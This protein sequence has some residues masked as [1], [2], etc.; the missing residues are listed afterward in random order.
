MEQNMSEQRPDHYSKL[1]DGVRCRCIH[2]WREVDG[3]HW[4]CNANKAPEP[5]RIDDD[6]PLEGKRTY[7][8]DEAL[9]AKEKALLKDLKKLHAEP[10]QVTIT[11]T[12][13]AAGLKGWFSVEPSAVDSDAVLER[14]MRAALEAA[15]AVTTSKES[16][17]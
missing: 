13:V 7:E 2:L 9:L 6:L 4:C 8:M 15:L 14:S 12:M 3:S 1:P 10:Q 11:D 5:V 16:A 17:A